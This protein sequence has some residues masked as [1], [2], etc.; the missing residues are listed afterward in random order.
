MGLE[1]ACGAAGLEGVKAKP[2]QQLLAHV[3]RGGEDLAVDV[4]HPGV[5]Q[6]V[7]MHAVEGAGEDAEVGEVAARCLDD[8]Q[9]L[10]TVIDGDDQD[11]R[12]GST[13]RLEQIGARGIAVI[14]LVAELPERIDLLAVMVEHHGANA[15]GLQDAAHR[16]AI[17]AV[18][19]DDDAGAAFI[20]MIVLARFA[21]AGETRLQHA[22]VEDHQQWCCGH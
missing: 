21:G 16:H 10:L 20:D 22:R 13:R 5:E 2:D 9:R 8:F 3:H 11:L 4:F 12:L 15:A 18:T 14:D 6:P 1:A 19:G 7:G 17:A